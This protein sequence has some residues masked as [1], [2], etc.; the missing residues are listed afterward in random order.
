MEIRE[1]DMMKF[2]LAKP[3]TTRIGWVGTGIMGAPMC[4]HLLDAGYQA[5]IYTRTKAKAE[6]LLDRGAVWADSPKE[7][8]E[9]ADVIFSI[10]GFPADVRQV[11]LEENSI[12]DGAKAGAI[13]VDMTT[14]EPSL[15]KEIHSAAAKKDVSAI[16]APV[17]GG[18]IGAIN[19]ALSIMVGGDKEAVDAVMP[20]FEIM[21]KSIGYQGAA[22]AGQHTK[23][24]NQIT[25]SGTLTGVSQALIYGHQA[26][27]DLETLIGSISKG[28]AGCWVLDHL[29][30]KMAVHDFDPGFYVEHFLKDLGIALKEAERMNLQLPG[31]EQAIGL[32]NKVV[33]LG[34]GRS[35]YH[36]LLVAVED[37]SKVDIS[38]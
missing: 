29:A 34:H 25:L 24:C 6:K 33:E 27:L 12:L 14:T 16:D 8:A 22:G 18:D 35:S 31:L 20:L 30:P 3:E 26:G 36:A 17:S 21:G 11:Y 23:M 28:A 1:R 32:Y 38:K 13:V 9:Q 15:S 10:V 5:I 2:E 19:A 37:L 7:V 4:G